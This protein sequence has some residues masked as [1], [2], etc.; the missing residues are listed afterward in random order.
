MKWLNILLCLLLLLYIFNV[1]F[2]FIFTLNTSMQDDALFGK[3][4]IVLNGS[5]YSFELDELWYHVRVREKKK[6][7]E[8]IKKLSFHLKI[9]TFEVDGSNILI[10]LLLLLYIFNVGFR[11]I[12][13]LN[14]YMYIFSE[15]GNSKSIIYKDLD[16]R[17]K[18]P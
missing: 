16:L 6:E 3:T 18:L 15:Y 9:F 7:F 10:C 13:I 11:F 1:G 12:F 14:I 17:V 5:D 8:I 4:N 2:G